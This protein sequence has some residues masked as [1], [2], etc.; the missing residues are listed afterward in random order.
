MNI[1][2]DSI[3]AG[4]ISI[5][6]VFFYIFCG[7]EKKINEKIILQLRTRNF[8]CRSSKIHTFYLFYL[9]FARFIFEYGKYISR[10]YIAGRTS[11][12]V[13]RYFTYAKSTRHGIIA[14]RIFN[15]KGCSVSERT[16]GCVIVNFVAP[17]RA[18]DCGFVYNATADAS[19]IRMTRSLR[20]TYITGEIRGDTL[21]IS[22]LSRFCRWWHM[23][24]SMRG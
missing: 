7:N 17:Y 14:L 24:L 2:N 19:Q 15:V 1:L 5:N 23:T 8:V 20:T 10:F 21:L 3:I 18:A 4:Y 9:I 16:P 11:Y 6:A 13:L 12:L 22:R